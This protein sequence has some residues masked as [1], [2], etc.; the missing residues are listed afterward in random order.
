MLNCFSQQTGSKQSHRIPVA[1]CSAK[2][3]TKSA[4]TGSFFGVTSSRHIETTD[5]IHDAGSLLPSN[6]PELFPRAYV[7]VATDRQKIKHSGA[8]TITQFCI[9]PTCVEGIRIEPAVLCYIPV[10]RSFS[11]HKATRHR[12][13]FCPPVTRLTRQRNFPLVRGHIKTRKVIIVGN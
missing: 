1:L 11:Y 2:D 7:R 10:G 6:R 3:P 9:K 4:Y 8:P 12:R 5:R 13:I